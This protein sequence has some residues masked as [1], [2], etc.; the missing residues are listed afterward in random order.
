[1]EERKHVTTRVVRVTSGKTRRLV[2]CMATSGVFLYWWLTCYIYIFA[3]NG[4]LDRVFNAPDMGASDDDSYEIPLRDQRYFG[5]GL[6]RKRV[7]FVASTKPDPAPSAVTS[8]NS[9]GSTASERYLSIVFSK[10]RS[11][12]PITAAAVES[13]NSTDQ[14]HLLPSQN[15]TADNCLLY[16]SPS[17]RDGLLSRMPSSA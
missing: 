2:P 7:Q 5:A 14:A 6:K 4:T 10:T 17:P 3:D 11:E 15:A 16:T 1:M 13:G 9:L 8:T 12:S